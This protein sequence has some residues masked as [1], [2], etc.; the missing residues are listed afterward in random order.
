MSGPGRRR[1]TGRPPGGDVPSETSSRR[2]DRLHRPS[3]FD[4]PA[5][6]GPTSASGASHSRGGSNPP[7]MGPGRGSGRVSPTLS[8]ATLSTQ[9]QATTPQPQ[10]QQLGDPARDQPSRFTDALRNVDLPASFYNIDQLVRVVPSSGNC[11]PFPS[12][13]KSSHQSFP[14]M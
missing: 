11:L 8:Q 7:S 5:S 12:L 1:G 2:G 4:G 10:A 6:R 13:L 3:A 14:T 9:A